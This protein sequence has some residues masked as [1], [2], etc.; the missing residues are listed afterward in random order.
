MK[1][2]GWLVLALAALGAAALA[3]TAGAGSSSVARSQAVDCSGTLKIA[4]VTPLTGG[5]GFIGERAAHVGEV[6]RRRCSARSTG[7]RSRSSRGDTP[8]EKGPGEA[9]RGR[10]EVHR[11]LAGRRGARARDIGRRRLGQQ[12][13]VRGRDAAHLAVRHAHVAD[14]RAEGEA[15]RRR[16]SSAS[17]RGD[18]IQGPT[19][20]KYMVDKLKAK[21]VVLV[22]FQEPYSVG[23]AERPN[24]TLKAKGVDDGP[25]VDVGQHDGL[26]VARHAACRTTRTS[27]SSRPSSRRTR[28]RSASSCSSRARGRRCSAATAR[29]ARPSSSSPARTSR[30]SRRTSA[31]SPTNKALIAGW[32]KDNPKATLGSFGPP[33]YLATQVALQRDQEGVRRGQGHDQEPGAV[34]KN[35]KKIVV[36][37]SILG[38][39]FRFSTKSNEPLNAKFYIFQ[40]QSNGTY[41]LVG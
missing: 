8:V 25:A 23:L 14:A 1:G 15:R 9:L 31:A 39:T 32:K 2:R 36:P 33:T 3:S 18:Y 19:D 10:A 4:F 34:L 11:R 21:K 13:A 37:N 38:G 24:A 5:G 6:R 41:K 40:I 35:V 17:S 20:A 30:T 22:D 12:G 16:R 29:T 27:S 26:L 28:R 7:S